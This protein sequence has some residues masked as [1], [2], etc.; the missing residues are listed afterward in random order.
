M[1]FVPLLR[2][3]LKSDPIVDLLETWDAEVVYDLD[4]LHENTPDSYTAGSKA[5]GIQFVFDSAQLLRT[6]FIHM[7]HEDGFSSADLSDSD[8]AVFDSP[9]AVT[10]FAAREHVPS[11]V[12][13]TKFLGIER[14][15]VRLERGSHTVHYEF[16]GGALRLI[17]LTAV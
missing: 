14:S 13:Q 7:R 15:W 11:S 1:L 9:E 5:A 17:T 12:G 8:I 2:Q 3:P 16:V 4:R 10:R 6:V